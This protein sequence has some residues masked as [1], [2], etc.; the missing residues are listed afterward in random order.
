LIFAGARL[1]RPRPAGAGPQVLRQVC[2]T[3]PLLANPDTTC[4]S[5]SARLPMRGALCC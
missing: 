4:G 5:F 1:C 2:D 3:A